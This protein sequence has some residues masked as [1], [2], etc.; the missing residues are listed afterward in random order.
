MAPAA[1]SSPPALTA[2][3]R[4]AGLRW[5]FAWHD[6]RNFARR[7]WEGAGE[8]NIPFL[9]SGLAFDAL[10]A[11]VPFVVVVLALVGYVLSANAAASRLDLASYLRHLFPSYGP[12][13]GAGPFEPIVRLAVG[14]TRSRDQ[15]TLVGLPLFVFFATRLFGSVRAAVCE[16]FDTRETRPLLRA[17]LSDAGLVM[18]T[19]LLVV[20]NV[21]LSEGITLAVRRLGFLEYFAAQLLAFAFLLV[22]FVM[23]FKYAPARRIRWDTALVAAVACALGVDVAKELLGSYFRAFVDPTQLASNATLGGLILLVAWVYY[24]S[25]V[26]LIGAQIAQVYELRR[27]QAAQRAVLR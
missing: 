24:M 21:V 13:L 12:Q 2:P 19:A 9:A 1:P 16:V 14:V 22:L 17:K 20:L 25:F 26:F 5:V 27:R 10:L 4:E 7:V 23:I 3:R 6:A 18:A 11:A 15:L 8:T